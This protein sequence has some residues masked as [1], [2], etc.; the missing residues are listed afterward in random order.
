MFMLK[1]AELYILRKQIK[2]VMFEY[3][4]DYPIHII[5]RNNKLSEE[6][7]CGIIDYEFFLPDGH[8]EI[9]LEYEKIQAKWQFYCSINS[10]EY[11]PDLEREEIYLDLAYDEDTPNGILCH[12]MGRTTS[13]ETASVIL[14]RNDISDGVIRIASLMSSEVIQMKLLEIR[15]IPDDALINLFTHGKY[16]TKIAILDRRII[17]HEIVELA[18][19]DEDEYIRETGEILAIMFGMDV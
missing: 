19:S 16:K 18:L 5:C 6:V 12:I 17:P 2:D 13:D 3:Y 8:E 10:E 11:L 7:V 9:S 15:N 14:N 1:M 4:E